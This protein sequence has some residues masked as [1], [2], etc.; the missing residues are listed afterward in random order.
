MIEQQMINALRSFLPLARRH[1]NRQNAEH[2]AFCDICR[3]Y[4]LASVDLMEPAGDYP[5]VPKCDGN[6]GGPRC[7]DPECWNDE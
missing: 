5:D 4:E 6:H 7:S 3:Y 1:Y 2:K